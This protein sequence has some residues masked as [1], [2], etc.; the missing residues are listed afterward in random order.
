MMCWTTGGSENKMRH[1]RSVCVLVSEGASQ[2]FLPT[3]NFVRVDDGRFWDIALADSSLLCQFLCC[4]CLEAPHS[5]DVDDGDGQAEE[6]GEG[7]G[8]YGE[9]D[10]EQ[11]DSCDENAYSQANKRSGHLW[12]G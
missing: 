8:P 3:V 7:V 12:F 4:V 5:D 1:P 9:I 10:D 11:D 2:V 6:S